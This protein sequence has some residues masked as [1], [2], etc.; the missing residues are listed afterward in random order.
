MSVFA[1]GDLHL[2]LGCD[3]PMDIFKGW[4]NYTDRLTENWNRV[5]SDKDTVIIPGDIS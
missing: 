4:D 5:V 3:K 2:S 1:I